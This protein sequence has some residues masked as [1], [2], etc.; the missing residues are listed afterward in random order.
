VELRLAHRPRRMLPASP[1]RVCSTHS[2]IVPRPPNNF[3]EAFN[4]KNNAFGFLRL[5]L[6]ILV[7]FSHS[8][9]LGGFGIDPLHALTKGR[10]NIGLASVVMFF[11]LS[12]FL[13]A[14]SA[15]NS[16][17]V[18]RFL[19]HRFLRIFPGYWVCLFICACV[20][21]PL[22]AYADSG[23]LTRIF[24]SPW[25]SPQLFMINN[26]G[27]LH[28]NG[29]SVE[30]VVM[31]RPN[32]ISGVLRHNPVPGVLNGSL[33]TLPYEL[34]CYLAVATVAAVGVLRRTKSLVFLLFGG[35]WGVNAFDCVNPE[36]FRRWFPYVGFE[37]LVMLGLF[38]C[39]GCICFLYREKIPYSRWLF[40]CALL[41]LGISLPAGVFG[42]VAPIALTY[43]FLWLA[44]SLPF[45]RF[46]A[47]GDF[48]YG[49]YIYAFPIQQGLTLMGL[50]QSGFAV[51]FVSS[52]LMTFLLAI[53]S[54]R[55][56]EAPCLRWKHLV[57]A[58]PAR[59][60]ASD[61]S[62]EIYRASAAPTLG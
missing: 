54:Y 40:M 25:N 50:P 41:V 29:F 24:S 58:V 19:W 52:L 18:P 32:S 55:L 43:A 20:I 13:I 37:Q 60:K 30:G 44:F 46:D 21:A 9:A 61:Q 7:V 56:V 53:F 17:S 1:N 33:W 11:V 16:A 2:A 4:A 27:I 49:T 6:A 3:A 10:Y 57:V 5:F 8:F 23:S 59:P 28:L 34:G 26:A 12:G 15:A 36:A 48:S 39:A 51:Y 14:R 38:F 47:R 22:M 62:G 35:L 31:F 45:A 42:L